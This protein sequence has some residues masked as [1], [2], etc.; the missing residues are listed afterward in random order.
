MTYYTTKCPHCGEY[1]KILSKQKTSLGCPFKVC[2]HCGQT[3]VD[4]NCYEPAFK[5]YRKSSKFKYGLLAFIASLFITVFPLTL[6]AY[7]S[8]FSISTVGIIC[9]V[10][11]L[12]IFFILLHSGL[13][14]YEK[15]EASILTEWKESEARLRKPEYVK[16][17]VKAGFKVPEIYT[18]GI[19]FEQED[20]YKTDPQKFVCSNCGNYS[21]GWYQT[22]PKCGASGKIEKTTDYLKKQAKIQLKKK[23]VLL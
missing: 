14:N 20:P 18:Y 9:G 8:K 13:S 16:S 3:Y 5:P 17:L 10:L 2:S 22:C 11:F 21:S 12:I 23:V 1:I 7:F 6:L 15:T 4:P 19:E